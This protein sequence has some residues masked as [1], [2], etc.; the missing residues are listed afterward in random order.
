M[1]T[2]KKKEDIM[3]AVQKILWN[4]SGAI[5]SIYIARVT[6]QEIAKW[7]FV[8]LV[9]YNAHKHKKTLTNWWN[10]MCIEIFQT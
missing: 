7:L 9:I 6:P 10:K 2:N 1:K 3:I 8:S 5:I 4:I